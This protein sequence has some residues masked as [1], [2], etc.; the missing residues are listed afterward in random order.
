MI[1]PS[2]HINMKIIISF[3]NFVKRERSLLVAEKSILL[4]IELRF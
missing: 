3:L 2:T 4:R 1:I